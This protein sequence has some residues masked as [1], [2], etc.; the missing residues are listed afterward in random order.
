M[1][2]KLIFKFLP[3][4]WIL[5]TISALYGQD[6][7]STNTKMLLLNLANRQQEQGIINEAK[8]T[9]EVAKR[10]VIKSLPEGKT[11]HA[12]VLT[13]PGFNSFLLQREGIKIN[14]TAG[15]LLSVEI[16]LASLPALSGIKGIRYVDVDREAGKRLDS[17]KSATKVNLVNTGTGL[18]SPFKGVGVIIGVIDGGFDFTH[19]DFKDNAGNLR[20]KRVWDQGKT[21]GT[22]PAGFSYGAEYTSADAILA[23]GSDN[24]ATHGSH[25]SGIAG[26]SGNG[27]GGKYAGMAPDAEL[28]FVSSSGGNSTIAD[29]I[30]Y[31]FDYAKSVGKPAVVN[32]SLGT[33]IGP[34]DGTS[35]LDKNIDELTS[36]GKIIVG[37]AGNEGDTKLHIFRNFAADPQPFSTVISIENKNSG[38]GTVDI[39]GSQN[40]S[41]SV[42]LS[43]TDL[44]GN[45]LTGSS[46]ITSASGGVVEKEETIG[47][48]TLAYRITAVAASPLNNKPN[49]QVEIM[50]K[51]DQY[52]FV[53]NCSSMDSRA[54]FWNHG[55]GGGAA[56]EAL[57]KP[58]Y[59]EGDVNYTVGE[60][61]GTA[62]GIISVGAYT[63]RNSYVSYDGQN[64]SISF[65]TECG[66]IAPFSSR[67]PTADER[68]KPEIAAPGNALISAGS[69]FKT[70]EP[71]ERIALKVEDKW[72]YIVSQGTSM[73]SPCVTGIIALF[74]QAKNNLTKDDIISIFKTTSITDNFTGAVPQAGSNTWGFGKIN[75]Y[76]G[77]KKI[78]E[79]TSPADTFSIAGRVVYS[80][81]SGSPLISVKVLLLK[82][83]A[84]I[85]SAVTNQS[86]EFI[87]AGKEKGTYLLNCSS[88]QNWGGVNSTDAL[89]IRKYLS[90]VSSFDSLQFRSADVNNSGSVNSTDALLIRKRVAGLESLFAAGDW[91]FEKPLVSDVTPY[92]VVIRG[93]CTG[94][95][96]GSYIISTSKKLTNQAVKKLTGGQ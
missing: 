66:E 29:A 51:S 92:P 57:P 10:F 39:W 86:G 27:S 24:T 28:V 33:H 90:G 96:N 32:M 87:F 79:L 25:V 2:A 30:K 19:P 62:R 88:S 73:S 68:V 80:T 41:F 16:P 7:F 76:D 46:A 81:P 93:L 37:A 72:P 47:T 43:I 44:N 67:G 1:K 45:V 31:I 61:G 91:V 69:S 14:S 35:P 42:S 11:V 84:V 40:S 22:P 50:N 70:N 94:D 83:S 54:H 5:I 59:V 9:P 49:I 65:Y 71:N 23:A 85:D 82:D 13:A 55:E 12:M 89:L 56:F 38:E 58:G 3:A 75:A 8:I 4:I 17:A 53:L 36:P 48:E 6:V 21:S 34:H 15:N 52:L 64:Q 78:L 60:I 63:S 26:G 77:I 74:L 20:I 95:V 18:S